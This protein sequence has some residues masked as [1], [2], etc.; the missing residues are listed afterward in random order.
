MSFAADEA[1]G[2]MLE[3]P[4]T[5]EVLGFAVSPSLWLCSPSTVFFSTSEEPDS[6]VHMSE[7][8]S[9]GFGF[10]SPRRLAHLELVGR[11]IEL[12]CRDRS[13]TIGNRNIRSAIGRLLLT[14]SEGLD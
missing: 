7:I 1:S 4:A 6:L 9:G 14:Y 12:R 8:V 2:L 11:R 13:K 10:R 5:A 3:A